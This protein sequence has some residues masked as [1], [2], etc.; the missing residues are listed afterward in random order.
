MNCKHIKSDGTQC[1]A[2]S[3]R[4]SDFCFWHHPDISEETK[5]E[6]AR[7]G[8]QNRAV[9]VKT[10]LTPIPLHNAKDVRSLI[11]NTIEA[12][13]G[14]EMDIRAANCLGVLSG[15]LMKAIEVEDHEQRIE[16]IEKALRASKP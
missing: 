11:A 9:K 4:G 6:A 3:L 13:R 16:E 12:V 8:G 10:P 1:G 5:T 2:I 15:Y 14:G 7:K